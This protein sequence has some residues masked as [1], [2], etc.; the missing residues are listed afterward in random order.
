MKKKRRAPW[1]VFPVFPLQIPY[2]LVLPS[3]TPR[4]DAKIKKIPGSMPNAMSRKNAVEGHPYKPKKYMLTRANNDRTRNYYGV[5][6]PQALY[7]WL[8]KIEQMNKRRRD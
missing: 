6:P 3:L 8:K 7:A 1:H 4:P 2:S 5:L